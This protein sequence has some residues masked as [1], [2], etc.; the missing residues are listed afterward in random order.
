MAKQNGRIPPELVKLAAQGPEWARVIGELVVMLH[1]GQVDERPVH[2]VSG[3]RLDDPLSPDDMA[4]LNHGAL[5]R[6]EVG[7]ERLA[8]LGCSCSFCRHWRKEQAHK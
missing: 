7:R 8:A 5:A 2:P 1:G 6:L 4:A 3:T